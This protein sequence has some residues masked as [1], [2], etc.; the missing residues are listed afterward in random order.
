MYIKNKQEIKI[1]REGGAILAKILKILVKNVKPGVSAFKLEHLAENELIKN[2]AKPAFRGFNGYKHCT[3]I[4]INDEVVHGLPSKEKIIQKN[5]LVKI[6]FG[7]LYKGFNSDAATTVF[8]GK[9]SRKVKKLM[10]TSEESLYLAIKQIKPGRKLRQIQKLIQK[11]IENQGFGV[12]RDLSGHG[13]GRD[14]QEAPSVPNFPRGT[15]DVTFKEGMT[16]CIEPMVTMG[17]WHVK[18]KPDNWTVVTADRSLSTHYEHT[19]AV[20]NNGCEILTK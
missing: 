20:T 15:V 18:T 19:L 9:P 14:L 5:D 3:C 1:M 13:I 2:H 10:D 6:D 11:Y 17:D 16:F 7:V 8:V 12:V 4:S